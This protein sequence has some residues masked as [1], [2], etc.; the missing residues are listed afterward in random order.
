MDT[1][2]KLQTARVNKAKADEAFKQGDV[3]AALLSYHTALM[4]LKGINKQDVSG[5][6]AANNPAPAEGA[7]EPVTPKTEVDELLDKIYSNQAACHIKNQNWQRA[8]ET[9]DQ[10]LAKNE[11][12]YK[13]MFRKAKALGEL[14]YFE[15]AERLLE[16]II[17]KN[18]TDAA[19]SQAELARLRALDKQ[20]EKKTNNK[21]KGFLGRDKSGKGIGLETDKDYH[22]PAP[23]TIAS[24]DDS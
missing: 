4:Y 20:R 8:W 22:K 24:G 13:A 14:G 21:M 11:T 9:A 16:D 2:T 19:P 17:S 15:R 10:A 3:K 1:E 12:N 5:A 7:A 6:M 18:P 23:G